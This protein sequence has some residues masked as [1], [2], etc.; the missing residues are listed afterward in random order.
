MVI[1]P[2]YEEHC[3]AGSVSGAVA[4]RE[5]WPRI[6]LAG[7]SL[8]DSIQGAFEL[9]RLN[10]LL[11][12]CF[13]DML[14]LPLN[15]F[16]QDA[17]LQLVRSIGRRRSVNRSNYAETSVTLRGGTGG[18]LHRLPEVRKTAGPPIIPGCMMGLTGGAV[19]F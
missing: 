12:G 11:I 14:R 15:R 9:F 1:R 18:V 5:A 4:G 19:L 10:F 17:S 13:S 8:R 2:G 16:K 7:I 3:L 6:L